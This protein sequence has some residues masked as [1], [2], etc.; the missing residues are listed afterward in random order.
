MT[1][2]EPSFELV[3]GAGESPVILHH[4]TDNAPGA[5]A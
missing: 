3:P 2:T 1:S 5:A 4:A